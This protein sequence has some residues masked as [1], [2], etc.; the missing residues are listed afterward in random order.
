MDNRLATYLGGAISI[1]S[2]DGDLVTIGGKL[3]RFSTPGDTDF[4][5]DFFDVKTNFMFTGAKQIPVLFEH[6]MHDI[7]GAKQLGLA[8]IEMTDDEIGIMIEAQLD[9]ADQ[10]NEMILNQLVAEKASRMGWSS[11]AMPST[12]RRSETEG[13]AIHI[14][15]W[16]IG[17]GSLTFLPAEPANAA[18]IKYLDRPQRFS[19]ALPDPVE[20]GSNPV[21]ADEAVVKDSVYDGERLR[22]EAHRLRNKAKLMG[23]TKW[24]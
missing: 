17:E 18:T 24:T 2:E 21:K 12:V 4:T 19:V 11:G 7:I 16:G 3:V 6:G 8:L 5:G 22:L 13:R 20:T 9:A 10:F 15:Q 1:K 23:V 14:D